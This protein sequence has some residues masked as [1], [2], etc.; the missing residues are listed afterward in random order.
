MQYVDIPGCCCC[1]LV[2]FSFLSL[3]VEFVFERMCNLY[4]RCVLSECDSHYIFTIHRPYPYTLLY[5]KVVQFNN[6]HVA[7]VMLLV[8]WQH[9]QAG[10]YDDSYPSLCEKQNK[11]RIT[12]N[13][14]LP[15]FLFLNVLDKIKWHS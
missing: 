2:R 7:C 12:W 6:L 14:S 5:I 11:K 8:S 1:F 13:S 9:T 15:F 4:S 10:K 3:R